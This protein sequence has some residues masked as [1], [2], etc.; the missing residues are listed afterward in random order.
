MRLVCRLFAC[1]LLL[2]FATLARA[3]KIN[4][5]DPPGFYTNPITSSPFTV[6][7]TSC[8]GSEIPQPNPPVTPPLTADGCFAGVNRTGQDWSSLELIV[9]DV[10][11]I[12][13]QSSFQCDT[14]PSQLEIFQG[15]SCNYDPLGNAYD[16][17]FS[18]GTLTNSQLFIITEDGIVPPEDFPYTTAIVTLASATTPEPSAWLLLASG[19]L[20]TACVAKARSRVDG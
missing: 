9:P 16:L 19:L 8:S 20:C 10:G 17:I 11:A 14:D 12:T 15:V 13:T 6:S 4:I 3:S 5:L 18:A 7:F 2:A 1:A